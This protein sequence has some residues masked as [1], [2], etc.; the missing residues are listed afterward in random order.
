MLKLLFMNTFLHDE[1]IE[2]LFITWLIVLFNCGKKIVLILSGK[3]LI[4]GIFIRLNIIDDND[5]CDC[6]GDSDDTDDN[7]DSDL[8]F[9]MKL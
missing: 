4:F 7:D 3:S 6:I 5:D 2:S 8:I 1:M 9:G